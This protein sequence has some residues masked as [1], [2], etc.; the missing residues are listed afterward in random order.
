MERV[1]KGI[2][3]NCSHHPKE[4]RELTVRLSEYCDYCNIKQAAFWAKP[5]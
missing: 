5:Y 1:Q 3:K 2:A 4:C